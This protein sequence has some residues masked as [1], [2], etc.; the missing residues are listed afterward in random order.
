[1][2]IERLTLQS[3]ESLAPFSRPEEPLLGRQVEEEGE[4]RFQSAGCDPVQEADH[5]EGETPAEPLIGD[6]RVGEAIAKNDLPS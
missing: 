5:P 3:V 6:R 2:K 1:M 4:V